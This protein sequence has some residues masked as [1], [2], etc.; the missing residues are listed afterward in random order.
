[1]AEITYYSTGGVLGFLNKEVKISEENKAMAESLI[2]R[3][4]LS[5]SKV[6]KIVEAPEVAKAEKLEVK[7]KQYKK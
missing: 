7:P 4:L 1:M 5:K 2:K 3:G 6:E